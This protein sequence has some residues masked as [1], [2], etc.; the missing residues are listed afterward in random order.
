MNR[1]ALVI[2]RVQG[3]LGNFW[4]TPTSIAVSIP[5]GYFHT[6]V[7]EWL[8]A[9]LESADSNRIAYHYALHAHGLSFRIVHLWRDR[10]T[11]SC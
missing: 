8:L 3:P 9:H 1:V 6:N 4:R 7:E 10:N 5:S 2:A 11:S